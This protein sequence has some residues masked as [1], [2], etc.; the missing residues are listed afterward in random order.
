MII[1]LPQIACLNKRTLFGKICHEKP[2]PLT[3]AKILVILGLETLPTKI[4]QSLLL[5]ESYGSH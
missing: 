3:S 1:H 5:D 2:G 4:I